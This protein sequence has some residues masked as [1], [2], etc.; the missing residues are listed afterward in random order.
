MAR[1]IIY[2]LLWVVAIASG[3]YLWYM[4]SLMWVAIALFVVSLVFLKGY[5][6][7]GVN[8]QHPDLFNKVVVITGANSGLGLVSTKEICKLNPKKVIMAC[9]SVERG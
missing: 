9:R 5:F 6:N 4:M 8:K 7:G 1:T 2:C 3:V